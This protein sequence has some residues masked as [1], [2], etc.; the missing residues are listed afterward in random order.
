MQKI[1]NDKY[2]I[3]RPLGGLNDCLNQIEHCRKLAKKS[4]R[5]LIIQTETGDVGLLHRF[6]LNFEKVFSFTEKVKTSSWLELSEKNYII[7]EYFPK[8]Y[9]PASI[10]MGTSLADFTHGVQR[11]HKIL[12]PHSLKHTIEI[13]ESAGGGLRSAT[14]LRYLTLEPSLIKALE[15]ILSSY[16]RPQV[17]IHFR[18]RDWGGAKIEPLIEFIQTLLNC[19]TIYLA[20][21]DQQFLADIQKVFPKI[22]FIST[23]K[24]LDELGIKFEK[25]EVAVIE[26]MFLSLCENLYV[27]P[28]LRDEENSPRFSGFSRLARHI[29]IVNKINE[30]G[31]FKWINSKQPLLGLAGEFGKTRNFI[32]LVFLGLPSVLY[33]ARF[34]TGIYSQLSMLAKLTRQ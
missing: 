16:G 13:H 30:N 15:E 32:Y 4:K 17:G 21:D 10:S 8:D 24:Y 34:T 3:C 27:L 9:R 11:E 12:N 28:L 20:M 14:L 33:E 22:S 6:S 1:V 7:D 26:L 2:L 31:I 25:T 23:K 18:A 19:D 29:W 5:K